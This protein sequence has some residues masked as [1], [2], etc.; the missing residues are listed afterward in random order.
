MASDPIRILV[1]NFEYPPIGGGGASATRYLFDEL[2]SDCEL[3]IDLVTSSMG[4]VREE[5]DHSERI[6]IIRLPVGKRELHYWA[7]DE[8]LR[9]VLEARNETRRLLRAGDYRLCHAIFG[10]PA[11]FVAYRLR[12]RL[13]YIVSLHGSDVPGFNRRF[14]WQYPVLKPLFRRVW[15]NAGA[16]TVVSEALR[17]LAKETE[18]GV[19]F[20]VIPNG[21]DT[22]RFRPP[23]PGREP[24]KRLIAVCRLIARKNLDL[25]LD[26]LPKVRER[27]REVSLTIVGE[28]DQRKDLEDRSRRLG[29]E[30]VVEFRGRV[31]HEELPAEYGAAD[32]FVLPSEWEGMP[33]TL[34]EAMACGLPA[35][36]TEV[37][38]ARE[39]VCENAVL[40]PP[41]NAE[42]IAG[43]LIG[44]L[45]APDRRKAMGRR[46]REIALEYGWD[47]VASRYRALYDEM[48]RSS[49]G[50]DGSRSAS[51]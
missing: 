19:S 14:S 6:H 39:V 49:P 48:A 47:K 32:L 31:P 38:G 9:Y 44:L 10:F 8:V 40:I 50:P 11:G 23:E 37:G 5:E 51:E 16:V 4:K 12:R 21:V 13:P 36:V 42:A 17:D 30:R 15:R 22:R 18:P 7:Q 29:L 43:A 28:G 1:L 35:V 25:L 33:M 26:V 20:R 46:S 41:G 34:L 45:D 3:R 2:T 27:H 24:G